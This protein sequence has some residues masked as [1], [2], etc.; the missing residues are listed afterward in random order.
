MWQWH[1]V[2]VSQL[3]GV[4]PALPPVCVVWWCQLLVAAAAFSLPVCLSV[5]TSYCL[6]VLPAV[7]CPTLPYCVRTLLRGAV[8]LYGYFLRS[9][10]AIIPAD[11]GL[12]HISLLF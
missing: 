7:G 8:R 1:A 10:M 11:V 9:P 2:A 5:R 12:T 4:S 6:P 3:I